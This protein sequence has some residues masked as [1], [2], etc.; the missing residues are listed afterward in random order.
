MGEKATPEALTTRCHGGKRRLSCARNTTWPHQYPGMTRGS[1]SHTDYPSLHRGDV[2]ADED[3]GGVRSITGSLTTACARGLAEQSRS[4]RR[5]KQGAASSP[6]SDVQLL[7]HAL[8]IGG[9][10]LLDEV[11]DLDGIGHPEEDV[12]QVWEKVC[13]GEAGQGSRI[14][15]GETWQALWLLGIPTQAFGEKTASLGQCQ[16]V[17][18]SLHT[19]AQ[20]PP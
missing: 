2:P 20:H 4:G 12:L 18:A 9:R 16:R 15:A 5:S 6:T 14:L 19:Q 17:F 13:D 10:F 11:E 8:D 3:Y 1:S 7:L